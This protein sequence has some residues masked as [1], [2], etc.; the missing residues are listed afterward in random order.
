MINFNQEKRDT[1][2]LAGQV[3]ERISEMIKS[4]NL[5]V[6]ERLPNEFEL[7]EQLNVG[8]VSYTHLDVYKRQLLTSATILS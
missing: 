8:P 3:A 4:K 7:A 1:T 2:P 5:I 6:G